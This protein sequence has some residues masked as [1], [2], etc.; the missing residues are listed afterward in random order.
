MARSVRR[1]APHFAMSAVAHEGA[2]KTWFGLSAPPPIS[3][4]SI[5]PNTQAVLDKAID[6]GYVGADAVTLHMFELPTIAFMDQEDVQADAETKWSA[7]V[8]SVRPLVEGKPDVRSVVLDTATEFDTLNVL[9]EFGKT[10]KIS[11]E[12]RRNRMGPV[13]A[14]WKGIIRA[15][16]TKGYNVVLLHRARDKW[17]S[18]TQ[19]G[20][21]GVEEVRERMT[22]LFDFERIGFKDTGF[23]TSAEVMLRFDPDREAKA[24]SGK[25]GMKLT[26]TTLRPALIGTEWWGREKLEDGSRISRVS[27]PY[28]ATQLY[29]NTSVEDWR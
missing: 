25:Y 6:E 11:P 24:L 16:E 8:E 15:L 27:F 23:I 12:S 18:K 22:G 10:D 26:R 1:T 17:E 9:A 4:H 7:F 20:V 28:L 21:R 19:R 14:R 13:N 29:P 2:G 5:D 3:Y